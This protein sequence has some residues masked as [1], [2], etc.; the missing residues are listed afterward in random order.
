MRALMVAAMLASLALGAG[1]ARAQARDPCGKLVAHALPH[2]R[3]TAATDVALGPDRRACK[4]SIT[5]RPTADSV[6]G[7]EVFIPEGSA[8]NGRFVQLGNGGFAGK[9]PERALAGLARAGYA[10]AATDDGHQSAEETD[11]RWALG[12]PQKVADYGWRA[13]KV[14]TDIAKALIRAYEGSPARYAY[15]A[16][17][18]DGGR[19]ALI[20]AQRF[21]TDFNG[22]IA[23]APGAWKDLVRL[24]TAEVQAESRPGGWLDAGALQTLQKAALAACGGG[25][26]ITNEAAC[27][28][29]PATAACAPGQTAGCLTSAQVATAESIYRG[30]VR[31]DGSAALPGQSP[32]AEAQSDGWAVWITGPSPARIDEALIYRFSQGVW[33][34][35]VAGEP[36]LDLRTVDLSAAPT[37]AE[38]RVTAELAA[39]DPDLS[40][41]RAAGGKLIAYHGWNDPAIPARASIAY[42]E[43][44]RRA[45]EGDV[46]AFY[47]LY[48]VPGMLHCGGGPG[49]GEVN[50]L[51]VMRAWV[52][53][54]QA[55]EG[56]VAR[57]APPASGSQRLCPY[58]KTPGAGGKCV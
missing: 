6:I 56:V 9:I 48:L 4:V 29:D 21:P 45:M 41:F 26:F 49:P 27:R 22:V 53:K 36:K 39:D 50:W 12:H 35:F 3:V 54:G 17:C 8:W 5:A 20:E 13:I 1:A 31:P 32:G 7:I 51:E 10:A 34:D 57:S 42:F 18:S 46:S 25:A 19:E 2:A 43:D 47:R 44:V 28:F 16:G 15:F 55:P 14:T 38:A 11:A 37:K 58:P 23:G 30:Y 33:G 40:K 24:W 52:E